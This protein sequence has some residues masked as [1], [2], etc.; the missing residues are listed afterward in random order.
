MNQLNPE[1]CKALIQFLD[2]TP[3]TGHG[4]RQAMNQLV[5]KVA[6]MSLD[7]EKE[8]E[9]IPPAPAPSTDVDADADL[10]ADSDA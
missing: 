2:R 6:Q 5:Q 8:T 1:E 7:G 3:I 9:I 4:E 10:D